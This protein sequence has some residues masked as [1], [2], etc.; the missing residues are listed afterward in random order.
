[1][2]IDLKPDDWTLIVSN[3]QPQRQFD[4]GDDTRLWGAYGYTPDR[5]VVRA[6]MS[7]TTLPYSMDQLTWAVLDMSD[8]AGKIAIM[9]DTT[10]AVVPFAVADEA[11]AG[12][13][14]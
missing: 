14:R 10:M 12:E 3:W 2:F 7:L 8:A 13:G 5:D 11:A 9:W 4:R 6:K 1:M